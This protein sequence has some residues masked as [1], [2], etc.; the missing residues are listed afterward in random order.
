MKML[1]IG[2]D[3]GDRRIVRAMP[4]PNLHKLLS[5]NVCIDIEEDLW[6]RGWAEIVS[7]VHGRESGAFY[8]KPKLDG[9]H[10]ATQK[11]DT[12]DYR[13]SPEI[14]PLWEILPDN[15]ISVGF[16]NVPS[17]MPAPAVE[18]FCISGGGAGASSA[19]ADTV[20]PG[21][22]YPPDIK[23]MLEKMDYILDT[24]LVSSGLKDVDA[25][26]NRLVV[27]TRRRTKA[28][29][30]LQERFNV[31]FG[32]LAYMPL[33]RVQNLAMSEIDALIQNQCIPGTS[34]QMKLI[35][36]YAQVDEQ[37]GKLLSALS[38]RHVML[39]SDHG[40]SS[41]HY[42][43]NV[44]DWLLQAGMQRPT[45]S[46]VSLLKQAAKV[47]SGF[48]PKRMKG[49]ITRAA[50]GIKD[51]V[52]GLQADWSLTRAF[53]LRYV[54]GIYI[55]D[56]Q[57]FGGPVKNEEEKQSLVEAIV[58]QFNQDEQAN[59]NELVA[60]VYRQKFNGAEYEAFLPE[61]WIDHPD[62][63]F[64]EQHGKFIQY[65]RDYGPIKNLRRV[66]RDMFTG[67]KGR[68]PLLCVSPNLARFMEDEDPRDLTL[69][70]KLIT[71]S[72]GL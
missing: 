55:N 26:L 61:I 23:S 13:S 17:M 4:M 70:Y 37:I 21:A 58:D 66:D 68:H 60:G 34:L 5:E 42:S 20:P 36:F 51:R 69:A 29:L 71:R 6:S 8:A 18:G 64:F 25:F 30:K 46:S 15:G 45:A 7:G 52:G 10:D 39:V 19:L 72:M 59:Q 11:F 28:F 49:Y 41:R 67:I 43:V 40:Q 50:P 48:L 32:F 27:M 3:G 65:N 31:Q 24:R 14:K 12:A 53:G 33:N 44:N 54:P 38:P 22:C 63:Y 2:I 9:T 35:R 57:R 56:R 62:T 47:F 16:M 1:V